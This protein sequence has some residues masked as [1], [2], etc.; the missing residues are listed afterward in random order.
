[1]VELIR[2]LNSHDAGKSYEAARLASIDKTPLCP[3]VT[4]LNQKISQIAN[5]H[6]I[7]RLAQLEVIGKL[8]TLAGEDEQVGI[9]EQCDLTIM[10][11]F[12]S[13]EMRTLGEL[14]AMKDNADY[15]LSLGGE[16]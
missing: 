2:L 5:N 14:Y 7:D 12:I 13:D 6:I 15:F 16:A 11:H 3:E 9:F 4:E 1:M 10:G 8:L